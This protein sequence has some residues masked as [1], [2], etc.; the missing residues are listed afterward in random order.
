MKNYVVFVGTG[1]GLVRHEATGESLFDV[2]EL[3]RTAFPKTSVLMC[4]EVVE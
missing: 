4:F 3:T 2:L 1:A